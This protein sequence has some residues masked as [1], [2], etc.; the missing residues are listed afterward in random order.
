MAEII[1]RQ[2]EIRFPNGDRET[3][4]SNNIAAESMTIT[5]SICD[6]N[7]KLGGC[8]ASSFE[9]QLIDIPPDTV[10]SKK[11]QA[12][13]ITKT[14]TDEVIYPTYELVPDVKLYPG[15]HTTTSSEQIMF[16]G[17]IDVAKRQKNR[18][19]VN[20]TAYDDLYKVCC[21]NVYTWFL[22]FAEY[23]STSYIS[24]MINSLFSSQIGYDETNAPNRMRWLVRWGVSGEN[25]NYT[26][27]LAL[28]K[29]L[30]EQLYKGKL[31]ASEIL[32]SAN[33][34]M[35][36]F[37]YI[38]P[39]GRY[40]TFTLVGQEAITIDKWIDL[41]FE[42]YRTAQV[43]NVTFL[44]NDSN[45]YTLARASTTN[46]CYYSDDNVLTMCS[47]DREA[48]ATLIKNVTNAGKLAQASYYSYRPFKLTTI[49]EL[50]PN[51]AGLG[52]KLKIVT[53][54]EDI[55]YIESFVFQEKITGIQSL[56][57]ELSAEGDEIL[58][59]Y[60]EVESREEI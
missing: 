23:S 47:T 55:P 14:S 37:G 48:V 6:G 22:R 39:D 56:K 41:E 33:E 59:G 13:I 42:E 1:D 51:G 53:G 58:S 3:I 30:V 27:P 15:Q 19:L 18:R 57:Y 49:A 54:E 25:N 21:K 29:N 24:T 7:L 60:D 11:I 16:T 32:K 44:Y 35:G 17:T 8:I 28:S 40:N 10:Q 20:I 45:R 50:L 2:L 46:N 43:D 26:K 5:H 4:T 12:V 31:T 36:L 34:L 52:S 38:M 9:L